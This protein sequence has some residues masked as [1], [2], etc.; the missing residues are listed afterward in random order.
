MFSGVCLGL[1]VVHRFDA[2]S[3]FLRVFFGRKYR[4]LLGVNVKINDPYL[5]P[6]W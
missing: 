1:C 6:E 3:R 4:D 2:I 5:L